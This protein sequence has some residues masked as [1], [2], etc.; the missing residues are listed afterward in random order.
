MSKLTKQGMSEAQTGQKL[1]LFFPL[2]VKQAGNAEKKI[3]K[4][5]KSVLH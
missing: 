4:R 5:I 3:L 1:G 2:K